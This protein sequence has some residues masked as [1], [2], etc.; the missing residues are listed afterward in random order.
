MDDQA[1]QPE[2]SPTAGQDTL[3]EGELTISGRVGRPRRGTR[4]SPATTDAA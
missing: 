2:P 3:E 1:Q 4:R